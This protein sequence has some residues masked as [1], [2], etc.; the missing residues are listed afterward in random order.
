[1]NKQRLA[2]LIVAA[3]GV[4]S[5]FLPWLSVP[6]VGTVNG[7]KGDGWIVLLL[8]AI[9]LVISL[10][11]DRT[12]PLKGGLLWGAVIAGGLAAIV[13]IFEI[14]NISSK[15]SDVGNDFAQAFTDAVSIEI[16]LY[17]AIIAG[18]ILPAVALLLK[19]K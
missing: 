11:K 12:Q 13:G 6:F 4:F 18:I 10:L 15:L 7:I 19:N 5:S 9:P 3:I 8:F 17:L 16:G 1:M 2:I 14:V